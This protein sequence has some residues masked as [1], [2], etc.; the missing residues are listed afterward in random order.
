MWVLPLVGENGGGFPCAYLQEALGG[1]ATGI[2]VY[3]DCGDAHSQS[4]SLPA[5]QG[6]QSQTLTQ[7][8][9][10]GHI[11]TLTLYSSPKQD[12]HMRMFSRVWGLLPQVKACQRLSCQSSSTGSCFP[13]TVPVHWCQSRHHYTIQHQFP[14][15]ANRERRLSSFNIRASLSC[16][17]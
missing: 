11:H 5:T 15:K 16:T 12:G 17:M 13:E 1:S 2:S 7:L 9:Q 8:A 4:P 6:R 3:C 14:Y 10:P